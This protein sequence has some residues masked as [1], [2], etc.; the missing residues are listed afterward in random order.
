MQRVTEVWM[1][2][3]LVLLFAATPALAAEAAEAGRRFLNLDLMLAQTGPGQA[4]AVPPTGVLSL[5]I[6]D[7]IALAL[8]NNLDIAVQGFN[9][10]PAGAGPHQPE[11]GVRSQCVPG[12]HAVRHPSTVGYANYPREPNRLRLLGLQHRFEA[13]AADR[14]HL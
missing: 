10:P 1:G 7:S 2:M 13:D 4:P 12:G 14:R 5:S 11:G 9:P 8:K 3:L 6:R